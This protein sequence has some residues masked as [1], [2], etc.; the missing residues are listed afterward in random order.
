MQRRGLPAARAPAG[1]HL[2][3]NDD[4]KCIASGTPEPFQS[5]M[6]TMVTIY[7]IYEEMLKKERELVGRLHRKSRKKS[8]SGK[9]DTE[10][11][12]KR[13]KSSSP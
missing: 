3:Y 1:Y 5:L 8:G 4:N 6:T 13:D 11:L 9:D 7:L 12:S 2:Q 10:S